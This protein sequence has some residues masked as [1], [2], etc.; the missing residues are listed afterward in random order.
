MLCWNHFNMR[1]DLRNKFLI[2]CQI[3]RNPIVGSL[4]FQ[5]AAVNHSSVRPCVCH[6]H[7]CFSIR[8]T[9]SCSD[10][11]S[12]VLSCPTA[13]MIGSL[14]TLGRLPWT[15]EHPPRKKRFRS[16]LPAR[17]YR[18]NPNRNREPGLNQR[19]EQ[20][21]V[22]LININSGKAMM[23]QFY[24]PG[25]PA[26]PGALFPLRSTANQKNHSAENRN[27]HGVWTVVRI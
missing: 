22:Y 18:A 27:G 19:N 21:S 12:I 5:F 9:N 15:H 7:T 11:T 2:W 23:F 8:F 17:A 4:T 16:I 20:M 25:C 26:W 10:N 24:K 14:T 13:G 6:H 3:I 1:W